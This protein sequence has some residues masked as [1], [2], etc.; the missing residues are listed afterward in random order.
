[1]I[2]S[3]IGS[4]F[5]EFVGALTKWVVYAVLHKVRGREIISFKEMWD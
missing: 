2:D 5:F 4:V 1:M 3:I